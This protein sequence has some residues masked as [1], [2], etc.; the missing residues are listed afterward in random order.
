MNS[1]IY[2]GIV[3]HKRFKP[4]KHSLKYRTF[5][6]LLDLE[7]MH[8]RLLIDGLFNPNTVNGWIPDPWWTELW[9][10]FRFPEEGFY[11]LMDSSQIIKRP[12]TLWLTGYGICEE[13]DIRGHPMEEIE[14]P[15]FILQR[16][17][18]LYNLTL[19]V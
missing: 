7:T 4:V 19:S 10:N 6:V 14:T 12:E 2:N 13:L 17:I 8:R 9:S 16:Y 18:D 3:T 5:S 11:C 15:M 1:C